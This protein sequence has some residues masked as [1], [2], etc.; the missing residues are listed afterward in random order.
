M[1]RDM[2]YIRDVLIKL[3]RGEYIENIETN[4][5][6]S[7]TKIVDEGQRYLYHLKILQDAGFITMKTASSFD[8]TFLLQPPRITW[9]GNDF[10]DAIENETVW[11]KTKEVA[12]AQGF[13]VAKM[14]IEV[15]K[16]LAIQQAKLI[17]NLE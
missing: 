5:S 1:I 8:G 16:S 17:F 9:A 2:E 4:D 11:G 3:S 12:K 14:S 6:P 7:E 13:E 10:L 15:L